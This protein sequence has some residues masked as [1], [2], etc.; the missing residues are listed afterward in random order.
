MNIF[1]FFAF[2]L[3]NYNYLQD[4][5]CFKHLNEIFFYLFIFFELIFCK[6]FSGNLLLICL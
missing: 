3:I 5:K 6:F 2:I 1:F 4:Q